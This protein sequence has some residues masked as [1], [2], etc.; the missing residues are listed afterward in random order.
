[1]VRLIRFFFLSILLSFSL[2]LVAC[3]A[4]IHE[5]GTMLDPALVA[6]I[7]VGVTTRAQVKEWLG[8]P[9]IV[10]VYRK[11]VWVYLQDRQYKNIQRTFARVINRVEITFDE[12]GVVKEIQHNFGD[13]LLNPETLPAAHNNKSWF[14]WL[15]DTEYMRPATEGGEVTKPEGEVAQ[16]ANPVP[17]E[18]KGPSE[19]RKEGRS[20]WRFWSSDQE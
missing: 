1:M 19:Q 11:D 9:T 15:W 8:V 12:R 2:F 7:K 5:K 17:D 3:Q 10:H 6:Q 16:V 14:G 18:Q 20:W 13:K 4:V